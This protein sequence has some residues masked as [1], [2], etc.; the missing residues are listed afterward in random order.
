MTKICQNL[1]IFV[2]ISTFLG[3]ESKNSYDIGSD[4]A[5]EDLGIRI[6]SLTEDLTTLKSE[7]AD[8][9]KVLDDPDI[10]A[11]LRASIRREIHQGEKF[12]KE[13][14]QW[15]AFLKIRRKK[16][17]NSLVDRKGS[18]TLKEEAEKEVEAYFVDKKLNPI[19]REWKERYRTA[20]EL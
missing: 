14:E 12:V 3:C 18:T 11:Q 13:I 20:I 7:L 8:V 19:H 6:T 16:R 17:Y 5:V 1:I 9:R 10:D 2:F 15:V 4:R